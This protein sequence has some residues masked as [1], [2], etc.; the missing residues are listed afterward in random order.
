MIPTFER[1][2]GDANDDVVPTLVRKKKSAKYRE[3]KTKLKQ[4]SVS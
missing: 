3:I 4:G 2:G 1:G